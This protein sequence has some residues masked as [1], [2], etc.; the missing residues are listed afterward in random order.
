MLKTLM[1]KYGVTGG[2]S[3]EYRRAR[4]LFNH[5]TAVQVDL[6]DLLNS[7]GSPNREV[8]DQE[9][10]QAKHLSKLLEKIRKEFMDYLD[11]L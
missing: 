2:A 3:E 1:K 7:V 5:Y 10:D 6:N 9:K 8:T 4:E 11:T